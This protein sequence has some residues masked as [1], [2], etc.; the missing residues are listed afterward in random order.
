VTVC[1]CLFIIFLSRYVGHELSNT[2]IQHVFKTA[3]YYLDKNSI[4]V[5]D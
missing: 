2:R 1:C 3:A 5:D 4:K